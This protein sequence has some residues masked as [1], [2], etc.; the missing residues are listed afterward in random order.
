MKLS[1]T[2]LLA[3]LRALSTVLTPVK[4][5][6]GFKPTIATAQSDTFLLVKDKAEALV[7]LDKLKIAWAEQDKFPTLQLIVL[8]NDNL[9]T[10]GEC[11][12]AYENLCYT[13]PTVVRGVDV[14]IKLSIVLGL[15]ISKVS[16][17]VWTFILQF[18][19]G[20]DKLSSYVSIKNLIAYIESCS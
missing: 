2:R 13:L 10:S 7:E 12:V 5:A 14:Y 19:Y 16:K 9:I 20:V 6:N 18:V 8:G 11:I 4:A 1:E 17:L 15:P 3:V